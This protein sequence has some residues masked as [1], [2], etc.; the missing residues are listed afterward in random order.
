MIIHGTQIL[1]KKTNTIHIVDD[2]EVINNETLVFTKD[3]KC[4]PISEIKRIEVQD[5][6]LSYSESETIVDFTSSLI[7]VLRNDLPRVQKPPSFLE[8]LLN[9]FF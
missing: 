6:S 3:M 4:F 9:R 1:N 5:T 2:I 7:Q 8:K